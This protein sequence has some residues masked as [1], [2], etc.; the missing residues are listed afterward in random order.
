MHY[1]DFMQPKLENPTRRAQNYLFF[2]IKINNGLNN[3]THIV[4]RRNVD[5][6][7]LCYKPEDRGFETRRDDFFFNI[8]NP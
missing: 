6:K 1:I 7:A 2:L 3:G 4:A 5:V 8:I